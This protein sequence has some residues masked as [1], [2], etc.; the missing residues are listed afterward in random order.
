MP[1][2]KIEVRRK[3]PPAEVQA[4]INAVYEAQR[5]ALKLPESKRNIR[6]VQRFGQLGVVAADVFIVLHE[7]P[8]ESWGIRG[9]PASELDVGFNLNV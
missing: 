9:V 7:P 6:I 5:E 3:R 8:L 1:L 4:F 2:A